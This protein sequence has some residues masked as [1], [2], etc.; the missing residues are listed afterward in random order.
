MSFKM[1][2][3]GLLEVS[4]SKGSLAERSDTQRKNTFLLL[5][6]GWICMDF[7][8]RLQSAQYDPT[9]RESTTLLVAKPH[10]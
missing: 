6:S 9:R 2:I 3:H 1:L 4:Y 8:T 7:M 10:P 5:A